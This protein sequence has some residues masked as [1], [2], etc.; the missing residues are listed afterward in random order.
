VRTL[1]I[2]AAACLLAQAG[3]AMPKE[4]LAVKMSKPDIDQAAFAAD[5]DECLAKA[6]RENFGSQTPDTWARHHLKV[7]LG[8][9]GDKGYKSDPAGFGA[10]RYMMQQDRGVGSIHA[11]AL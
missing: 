5:R 7:F 9:M 2:I 10:I 1:M 3:L 6:N 8:C 4:V 11:E